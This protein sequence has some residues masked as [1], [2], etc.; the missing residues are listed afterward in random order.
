MSR[1]VDIVA[2]DLVGYFRMMAIDE[3]DLIGRL[4]DL[5]A[6]VSDPA[7]ATGQDYIVKTMSDGT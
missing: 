5:R 6:N 3:E 1:C 4:L 2:A 7:I